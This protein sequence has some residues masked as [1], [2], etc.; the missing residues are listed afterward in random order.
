MPNDN[1]MGFERKYTETIKGIAIILMI[2]LHLL[3]K[4][5][6]PDDSLLIDFRMNGKTVSSI[7]AYACDTCIGIF[8]FITGYGWAET[9]RRTPTIKRV[10]DLYKTYWIILLLFSFPARIINCYLNLQKL[11]ISLSE[12][13]LSSLAIK[14]TSCMFQWYVFFFALASFSFEKIWKY[15]RKIKRPIYIQILWIM[16]ISVVPRIVLSVLWKYIIVP[17]VFRDIISHYI[18]WMPVIIMGSLANEYHIFEMMDLK[19]SILSSKIKTIF[20]CFFPCFCI[21]TKGF[22]QEISGIKTNVDVIF[23]LPFMYCLVGIAQILH[24]RNMEK[25]LR[26]LGG[27]STYLWLTHRVFLYE[28]LRTWT[29]HL[30][31]SFL[32]VCF[33]ILALLP[34]ASILKAIDSRLVQLIHMKSPNKE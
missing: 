21:M 3:Q 29:L 16:F 6:M 11:N 25:P 31:F 5:W 17:I 19:L 27:V 22:F 33:A 24:R 9:F 14:S 1:H 8:A 23:I 7:I 4:R 34:F 18:S 20:L 28:P 12:V 13:V 15:V 26:Y 10:L 32:I 30:R 2:F